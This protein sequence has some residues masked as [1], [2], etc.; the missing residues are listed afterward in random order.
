MQSK[1]HAANNYNN[2]AK[3][4]NRLIYSGFCIFDSFKKFVIQAY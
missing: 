1:I 2:S 3:M 4:T